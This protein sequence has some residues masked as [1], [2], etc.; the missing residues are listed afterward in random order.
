MRKIKLDIRTGILFDDGAK[1]GSLNSSERNIL[2]ELISAQGDVCA[3]DKLLEVGWPGRVV[4]PAALNISIKNIRSALKNADLDRALVTIPRKGYMLEPDIISIYEDRYNLS[5][6][7]L[8]LDSESVTHEENIE[9]AKTLSGDM[10]NDNVETELINSTPPVFNF[11]FLC[12]IV[13]RLSLYILLLLACGSVFLS[14]YMYVLT[15]KF[16]CFTV[17]KALFC[18]R[19]RLSIDDITVP[20]SG[21]SIYWF[22]SEVDEDEIVFHKIR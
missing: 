9:L 6:S 16:E 2:N 13:R 20:V 1:Y 18:G 3:K 21:D 14:I 12:F 22:T 10:P 19:E 8:S 17:E 15:P 4:V 11:R 5:T 7:S